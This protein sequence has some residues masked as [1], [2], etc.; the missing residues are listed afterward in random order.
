ML[1]YFLKYR[2]NS[3]E[4][5]YP[6]GKFMPEIHL[7]QPKFTHSAGGPFTKNKNKKTIK[8]KNIKI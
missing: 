7:R 6:K 5:K 4:S 3:K 8:K 2:K 1:S